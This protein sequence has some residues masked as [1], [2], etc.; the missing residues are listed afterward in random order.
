VFIGSTADLSFRAFDAK[1]GK[2]VWKVVLDNDVVMTPMTYQGANG[3]QYVVAVP[4]AGQ[5]QF[6]LPPRTTRPPNAMVVAFAL[7]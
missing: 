7:P 3:K 2:E 5:A 1:T 6:H 4:S